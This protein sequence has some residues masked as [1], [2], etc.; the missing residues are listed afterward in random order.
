MIKLIN[1]LQEIQIG[2]PIPDRDKLF[3]EFINVWNNNQP[4]RRIKMLKLLKDLGFK[5]KLGVFVLEKWFNDLT[6]IQLIQINSFL[7]QYRK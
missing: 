6:S 7:Q 1:I 4:I 5:G 2:S 3:D